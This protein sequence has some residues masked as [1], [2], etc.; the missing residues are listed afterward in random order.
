[1][2]G[3]GNGEENRASSSGP[4]FAGILIDYRFQDRG[5]MANPEV[6]RLFYCFKN[7]I[8]VGNPNS[9]TDRY[10]DL[11]VDMSS[12]NRKQYHQV[13]ANGQ[14]LDY[15]VTVTA[16]STK[17]GL[18]FQTAQNNWTTRNAVKKTAI[19]W[20]RQLKHGGVRISDLPVYARRF[21]C[22]MEQDNVGGAS[23][24]YPLLAIEAILA[25][26]ITPAFSAYSTP[27]PS[28]TAPSVIVNRGDV[29]E[30]VMIPHEIDPAGSPGVVT[31][32]R[33]K[34]LGASDKTAGDGT[35][36]VISEFLK[37]RRNMGT[38]SDPDVQF[39]DSDNLLDTLYAT[40]DELTDDIV[41]AAEDYMTNRPYDETGTDE[42]YMGARFQPGA[43]GAAIQ[44]SSFVAPLGLIKLGGILQVWDSGE[45]EYTDPY[46]FDQ[47]MIDVHAI[48]EM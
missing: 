45:P 42:L 15:A 23:H 48:Y 9:V 19:G 40:A 44:S 26:Q 7:G 6:T 18:T 43:T 13:K 8:A 34:L 16:L 31:D 41:E 11:S 47:F 2:R 46:I 3:R 4:V 20:K 1:V 35:F 27:D 24:Q 28:E 21:R 17:N 10:I 14:P 38:F 30:C 5:H 22:L 36:G 33:M 25:D 32:F 12:V 37:S 29:S 39:P